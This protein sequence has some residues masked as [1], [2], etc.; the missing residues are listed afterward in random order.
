MLQSTQSLPASA[1]SATEVKSQPAA[2]KPKPCCVCKDEKAL[3]DE[4]MLFSDTG[5]DKCMD[6]IAAYKKC[7]AGYGFKV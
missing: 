3:R 5:E 7:M 1:A 4:C 6:Q 2:A